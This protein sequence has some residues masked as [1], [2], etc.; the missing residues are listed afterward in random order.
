MS[1][2]KLSTVA[3]CFEAIMSFRYACRT[4]VPAEAT[5]AQSAS[6]TRATQNPRVNPRTTRITALKMLL[7]I[8]TV[9]RLRTRRRMRGASQPPSTSAPATSAAARPAT[10]YARGSPKSSRR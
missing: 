10:E 9:V 7:R 3:R 6:S 2:S 1:E 8:S 4:G 5:T